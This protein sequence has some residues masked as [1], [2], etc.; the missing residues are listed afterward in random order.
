MKNI[1]SHVK[2]LW[3]FKNKYQWFCIRIKLWHFFNLF[4]LKS[5]LFFT[6]P[7]LPAAPDRLD[8]FFQFQLILE[9]KFFH[10][11]AHF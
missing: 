4:E 6:L 3:K 7:N 8:T 2:K 1:K 9:Q 10:K 11:K 5:D